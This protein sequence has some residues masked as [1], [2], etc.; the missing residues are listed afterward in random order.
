MTEN[1]TI[2]DRLILFIK[3]LGIGQTKFEARCG[4]ANGYVNNIRKSISPDKLQIIAQAHPELNSGWLMTGEGEM[5]R[6]NYTQNVCGG[7]NFSQTGNVTVNHSDPTLMKMMEE[8][9]AQLRLTEKA[10]EQMDR[11]IAIIERH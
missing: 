11:L 4:L 2:K 8:L 10:Q 7:E 6:P 1:Q 5:L 3:H 9:S